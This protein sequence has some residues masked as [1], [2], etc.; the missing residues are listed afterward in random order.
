MDSRF[1]RI[2]LHSYGKSRAD[3]RS[4]LCILIISFFVMPSGSAQTDTVSD[5]LTRFYYG[6]GQVSSEGM[7][8]NGK[9]DGKWTTYYPNGVIKSVGIRSNFLLDS[10]WLFFNE[11]GMLTEEI[12]YLR[13]KKSGYTIK[14]QS[15]FEGDTL[16]RKIRSR[17]LFLDDLKEDQGFYFDDQGK[18]ERIV[19]Y[20]KGM[21]HGLTRLFNADS[22]IQTLYKYHNGFLI[23]REFINQTDQE[24]RRH[25]LWKE[26]YDN[27]QIKWEATYRNGVLQGYY[28]MY[29][30]RGE[31]LSARFYENGEVVVRQDTTDIRIDFRNEFDED[32]RL[33]STGGYRNDRPV[34]THRRYTADRSV[35]ETVEYSDQGQVISEGVTDEKGLR[36]EYWTF[37]YTDGQVR[38][39][40]NFFD[41]QRNG[42]WKFY[43]SGGQL[44][45]TGTYRNGKEDGLWT[46]YYPNGSVWREEQ[47]FRG[48]RDGSFVEY[49]LDNEVI[50]KGEFLDG[51][52]EG[53]WYY[54]VGDHTEKGNYS[55]G[56]K[57]GLWTYTHLNGETKFIGAYVQDYPNGRHRY[58]YPDGSLQEERFY[59]MGR[60]ERNWRKYDT[61]GNVTLTLTY[62]ND[63]LLRINGVRVSLEENE[64]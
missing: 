42:A 55:G 34:G 39:E 3:M 60:K 46:W 4:L 35:V 16:T 49:S 38:S 37:Y 29:S 56:L 36:N 57:D 62:Q 1:E 51:L 7:M 19:R 24:G 30:E 54:H 59:E 50:I 47:Y 31:L 48:V 53:E 28:R 11:Q 22:V 43:Y 63:I 61:E 33:I 10:I 52:E 58:F 32:G 26:L 40:G 44:E 45:Q 25:G 41:N 27:D 21:K 6:N 9:P 15:V 2:V 23:D 8:R 13:G 18:L 5:G 20:K 12:S 64:R 14:Y 17:E